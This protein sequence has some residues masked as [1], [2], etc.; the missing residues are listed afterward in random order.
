MIENIIDANQESEKIEFSISKENSHLQLTHEKVEEAIND[1][2]KSYLM[3]NEKD[4]DYNEVSY[5]HSFSNDYFDDHSNLYYDDV[6]NDH[7]I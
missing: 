7:V 4:E 5:A 3:S 6:V 2:A 1:T